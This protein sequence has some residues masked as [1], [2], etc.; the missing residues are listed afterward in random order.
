MYPSAGV[1]ALPI[2]AYGELDLLADE[3]RWYFE[4]GGGGQAGRLAACPGG[5]AGTSRRGSSGGVGRCCAVP[6][7]LYGSA[8]HRRVSLS[9]CC[10]VLFFLRASVEG[11]IRGRV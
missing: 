3:A 4:R 6:F 5:G 10:F 9:I 11:G 2:P 7:S 8:C 1:I